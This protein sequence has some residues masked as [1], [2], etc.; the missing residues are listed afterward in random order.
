MQEEASTKR[1][2]G[3][4]RSDRN[5]NLTLRVSA[6]TRSALQEAAMKADCSL[7]EMAERWFEFASRIERYNRSCGSEPPSWVGKNS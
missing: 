6:R 5:Y 4:P 7:S 1:K 3:R 2:L